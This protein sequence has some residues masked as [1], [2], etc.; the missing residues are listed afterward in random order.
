MAVILMSLVMFHG[1]ATA[2]TP[3]Q[4]AD[5][6]SAVGEQTADVIF[7]VREA[8]NAL[9]S[10]WANSQFESDRAAELAESYRSSAELALS[11][12][13]Q[14]LSK[15]ERTVRVVAAA[16]MLVKQSAALVDWIKTG[17]RS[18]APNYAVMQ[19]TTDALLLGQNATSAPPQA[20]A[21]RQ[22]VSLRIVRSQA[23]NGAAGDLGTLSVVHTGV[24]VPERL[25]WTY[26]D[27]SA[28]EG[29]GVPLPGTGMLAASFGT[30]VKSIHLYQLREP[31][32][33]G[34][35]IE[36]R[37]APAQSGTTIRSIRMTAANDAIL[38]T[39]FSIEGG[40]T[41]SMQNR[42]TGVP[43]SVKWTFPSGAISGV[44][45]MSGNF[46]AAI[47]TDPGESNGVAL[48]SMAPD[49]SRATSRWVVTGSPGVGAEELVVT[50][51]AGASP[52]IE[53]PT[54][55][56][57]PAQTGVSI[58]PVSEIRQ[59]AEA[60]RDDLGNA[61]QWRPTTSQINAI[62]ATKADA[63]KLRAYVEMVYADLSPGRAAAK[64][65]QTEVVVTGPDLRDLAGGYRKYIE[66][67]RPG[68]TI[69]GFKYVKPGED[70]GMRYDGIIRVNDAWIFIP[71][72]WRAFR[73]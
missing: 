53:A 37:W 8:I 56:S 10:G 68:T 67:F 38:P 40:G 57:A 64:G 30:R 18:P 52:P 35:A 34:P 55:A 29:L 48:Y 4:K 9:G 63:D 69:Y 11:L 42:A 22:E 19:M 61:S 16:E 21:Q 26:E 39:E 54:P 3:Q 71:K 31:G 33:D 14:S 2:Q 73:D 43:L 17:D 44:G 1:P 36:G 7:T 6:A 70:S 60:L 47:A 46:L 15:N 62:S 58:D 27:G 72:A 59:I 25:N 41:F 32:V 23:P 13:R 51:I 65:G 12:A 66:H 24:T 5:I 50:R 49:A 45:V 28:D 20:A